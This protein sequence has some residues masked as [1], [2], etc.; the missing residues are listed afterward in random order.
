MKRAAEAT[1]MTTAAANLGLVRLCWK[2][3]RKEALSP[4]SV[5]ETP[6]SEPGN[7]GSYETRPR[8]ATC[9][10]ERKSKKVNYSNDPPLWI[11]KMLY[12]CLIVSM[13][14]AVSLGGGSRIRRVH[15]ARS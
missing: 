12:P 7:I 5:N 11:S 8:S 13:V 4:L 15:P 2:L 1:S 9:C 3:E 6:L 14:P 10:R